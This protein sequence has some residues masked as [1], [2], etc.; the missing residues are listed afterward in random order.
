M[1]KR[2]L[3]FRS[4]YLGVEAGAVDDRAGWVGAAWLCNLHL[5]DGEARARID[6][7]VVAR[8]ELLSLH[9]LTEAHHALVVGVTNGD[10]A[11][12]V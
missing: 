1:L 9:R 6:E 8:L 4:L 7:D 10:Q 2:S 11:T 12:V 3:R 5:L